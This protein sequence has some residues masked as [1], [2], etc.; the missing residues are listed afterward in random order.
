MIDRG[1]RGGRF[2]P[3]PGEL[4]EGLHVG[5]PR[6]YLDARR[7]GL[8]D[9]HIRALVQA[10]NVRGIAST[11]GSCEGHRHGFGWSQ[12][13]VSFTAETS[14]VGRL[15]S[16]LERDLLAPESRLRFYWS[17]TGHFRKGQLVYRL[18]TSNLGRHLW[19]TRREL[20]EDFVT[21]QTMVGEA[22]V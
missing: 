7:L 17:V 6:S 4:V 8:I 1:R 19:V 5:A 13:Y 22:F 9:A 18:A 2:G 16:L 11:E 21:L 14:A 12:P 15:S 3:R 20:D 10:M